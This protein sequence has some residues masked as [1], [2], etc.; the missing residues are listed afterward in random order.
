M[1][2]KLVPLSEEL[3][4]NPELKV[5]DIQLLRDWLKKQ[6]H[7]PE[8]T[9]TELALFLHCNYYRSEPA[10]KNIDAFYS[11]RSHIPEFFSNRDLDKDEKLKMISKV[12]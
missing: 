8:I 6:P 7:L 12:V 9:D 4:R 5:S 1:N 3:K 10:K 11:M 2:S